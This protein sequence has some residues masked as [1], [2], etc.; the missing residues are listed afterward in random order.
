MLLRAVPDTLCFGLAGPI[1][2]AGAGCHGGSA[3]PDFHGVPGN[4]SAMARHDPRDLACAGV[5]A[6]AG[7]VPERSPAGA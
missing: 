2:P 3:P 1:A 6:G 7:P 4:G 5:S